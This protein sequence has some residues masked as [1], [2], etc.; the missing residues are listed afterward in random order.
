MS[1]G[2]HAPSR[3]FSLAF[4]LLCILS[5][6]TGQSQSSSAADNASVENVTQKVIRIPTEGFVWPN[7]TPKD[8]PFEQS[9]QLSGVY[10]TGRQH[11]RNYGDT[12][13]PS[14]ASD[15]N[16]YS[17]WTDGSTE[18]MTSVSIE[19]ETDWKI[20]TT[21]NSVM[22]GDDPQ[23]LIVKNTSEPQKA[24]PLPFEGRYPC[25][26]LVYN[27]VWYY[28][29]YCLGPHPTTKHEGFDYNWPILG[30][31]PGFRISTDYG[32]TWTPSPLTPEKPL[33]P[34]PAKMW[35]A[36]K[37]GAPH[38]VDFGKNMEHSPD[39][40]AYLV[41]MGAEDNDPKPRYA[42]LSWISGD[43]A[44]LA[45]VTPSIE[46]INNV[47]K[48]EFFAGN[49][50][51]GKPIWTSDFGKIKPLVDWNN[52]M[53]VATVTYDAP[54]KKYLMCVTD[55][56]PTCAKMHTYI[57]ESD[58]ITGPWRLV[59]YMKD[60]GEQ[61]YFVNFPSKFISTDGKTMW[62]LFSGNF[63]SG[64][65][66]AAPLKSNPPGS[67]YGMSLHEVRLLAPGEEA[68]KNEP[69]PLSTEKNIARKAKVEVSSCYPGYHGEGAVDGVVGGFPNN[70]SQEWASKDEKAGAW[71]KLSWDGPQKIDR[72]LLF[73]RPNTLDQ[74]TG[75]TLTFSDGSTIELE[76]PLADT[77][78]SGV[79]ITFPAKTATWVKFTVTAVK[80]DSPNI[81]LS[82]I[83]VMQSEP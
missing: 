77:A 19:N 37:M 10:F 42:N 30:P 2:N 70:L 17:P 65:N 75:G 51:A 14:W 3:I 16:M 11:T 82:E 45:R 27:G 36:V 83:G 58:A 78:V 23:N 22:I 38:F 47:K 32:K 15:G 72:V 62:I 71:I 6:L 49:D 48:Y 34:E 46:S 74:V 40:K 67:G 61:A 76:K 66:G 20:A 7:Q 35:G 73:D 50:S 4:S 12:W 53:G 59:T 57:L 39:G 41:G 44:Y 29:T 63:A 5:W 55:G 68:P 52:N 43:Q 9:K 69:N 28:G 33:F 60:F 31:M 54:L 80:K 79:E 64:W 21:G 8:C 24:S 25:G 56:W 18:G 81:G 26:S 1:I 13:Y